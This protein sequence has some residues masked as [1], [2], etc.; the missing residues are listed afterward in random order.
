MVGALRGRWRFIGGALIIL[1]LIAVFRGNAPA[2]YSLSSDNNNQGS[3]DTADIVD[4]VKEERRT[5]ELKIMNEVEQALE[6]RH[7]LQGAA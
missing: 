2:Q 7:H 1:A 5:L 6:V 3:G 4:T